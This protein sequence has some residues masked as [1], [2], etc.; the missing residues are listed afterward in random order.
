MGRSTP[1]QWPEEGRTTSGQ[2]PEEGMAER[3]NIIPDA[4]GTDW[5]GRRRGATGRDAFPEVISAN[6]RFKYQGNPWMVFAHPSD[7]RPPPDP[8]RRP[9]WQRAPQSISTSAFRDSTLS[10][11]ST[12]LKSARH[13]RLCVPDPRL[14]SSH[15]DRTSW[16]ACRTRIRRTQSSP[17][18]SAHSRSAGSRSRTGCG[19]R[20]CAWIRPTTGTR[21]TGI[22]SILAY[23]SP[24]AR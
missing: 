23:V 4:L 6:A 21:P 22:S 5:A 9:Q 8:P 15:S 11:R 24:R 17:R 12:S 10:T 3:H 18:S 19:L 14:P 16:M 7:T 13:S 1:G 20:R 2:W